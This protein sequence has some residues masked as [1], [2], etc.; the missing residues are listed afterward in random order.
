MEKKK[1]NVISIQN[2]VANV[3]MLDLV[4]QVRE[5]RDQQR[6]MCEMAVKTMLRALDAKD[7][8]TY[9]HSMRVAF[10]SVTLGKELGLNDEEMY[11]LEMSALFHDIG[12][13]GV[14]DAVL[15]KP[16]RLT[17]E[18]FLKMKAHPSLTAEILTD[19]K[20]FQDIAT[21]AKHHHERFDGRGYP[22]GLAGD[23][24][25]LYSRIILIADTF[26]AMTSTRPYRK[27]LPYEVAFNELEEFS[28]SQF[29]PELV[30][31]FISAMTKEDSKGEE[32][33]EL[34]IVEGEFKKDAA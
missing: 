32:T 27:G 18:E 10:Y 6:E 24:I 4:K 20:Y 7:N 11:E 19:F 16:A 1:D 5:L 9:G 3:A 29:D 28:G 2:I 14:P 33:F 17:E 12:K 13:I 30:K 25:P 26:D 8:Y 31:H 22:D 15:L 34:N 21:Y 23:D